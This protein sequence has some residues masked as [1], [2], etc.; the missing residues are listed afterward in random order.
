MAYRQGLVHES[1][2]Y[3]DEIKRLTERKRSLVNKAEKLKEYA[4]NM[5]QA[6]DKKNHKGLFQVSIGKPSKVVGIEDLSLLPQ[7]FLVVK[8]EPNKTAIKEA[9]NSGKEV[10]GA[11][12]IDGKP[13]VTIK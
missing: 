2:A 3:D 6:V 10:T 7:E 11:M 9:I 4:I 13:R 1:T 8:Y 12:I 5:M